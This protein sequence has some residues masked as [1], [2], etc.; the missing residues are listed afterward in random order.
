MWVNAAVWVM[1]EHHPEPADH[2]IEPGNLGPKG[3]RVDGLERDVVEARVGGA[4]GGDRQHGGREVH[5]LHRSG[6]AD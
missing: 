6:L 4:S 1:E 5:T 3:S 2:D